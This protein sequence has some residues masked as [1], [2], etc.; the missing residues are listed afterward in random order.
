MAIISSQPEQSC[1]GV[2]T[3]AYLN[4]IDFKKTNIKDNI[5]M[6]STSMKISIGIPPLGEQNLLRALLREPH[7]IFSQ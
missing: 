6:L 2:I 7:N 1:S 3:I 4:N 5:A